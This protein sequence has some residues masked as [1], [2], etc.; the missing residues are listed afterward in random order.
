V[1]SILPIRIAS[2]I[3]RNRHGTFYFR[4][5]IPAEL[6][7][8]ARRRELRLTFLRHVCDDIAYKVLN[9]V[10]RFFLRCG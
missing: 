5:V 4:F 8:T 2:H 7:N 6:R 10:E 9:A 1:E 3:Y